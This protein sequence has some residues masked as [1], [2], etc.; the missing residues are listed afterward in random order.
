MILAVL[1]PVMALEKRV[2]HRDPRHPI[3]SLGGC[4]RAKVCTKPVLTPKP[5]ASL[6]NRRVTPLKIVKYL[7]Q[8][9]KSG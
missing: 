4:G 8:L 5:L 1:E 2:A 6:G 9:R 7:L 3:T